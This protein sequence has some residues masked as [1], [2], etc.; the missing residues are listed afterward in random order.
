MGLYQMITIYSHCMSLIKPTLAEKRKLKMCQRGLH[1]I[2]KLGFISK[3]YVVLLIK[4]VINTDVI[5]P[6]LH[7]KQAVLYFIYFLIF[8]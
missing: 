5:Y 2:F 6:N 4:L 7:S 1:E 3:L 8:V